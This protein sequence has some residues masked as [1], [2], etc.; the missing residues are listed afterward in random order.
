MTPISWIYM[1]T[2][3]TIIITLNIYCFY[4]IFTKGKGGSK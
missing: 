2:V 3:W 4:N 1:G